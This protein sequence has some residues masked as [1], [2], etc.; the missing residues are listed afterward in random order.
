MAE[1]NRTSEALG[2]FDRLIARFP[3]DSQLAEWLN[4][5]CWARATAN[6]ELTRAKADCESALKLRPGDSQYLDSRAFLELRLGRLDDAR[7]DYDAA[8]AISPVSAMTY[9]G[10]GLVRTRQGDVS[11]ARADFAAAAKA[12][13]TAQARFAS[14][15][16][17][18]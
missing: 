16:L 3:T 17:K 7:R 5:R 10:R 12:D 4:A 13:P 11:G 18:P 8:A 9:Y 6:I 1:A 2:Y 14:W 15:G